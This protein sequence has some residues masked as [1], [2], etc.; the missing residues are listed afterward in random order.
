M[1]SLPAAALHVD[2]VVLSTAFQY[3]C[4]K[5]QSGKGVTTKYLSTFTYNISVSYGFNYGDFE[6]ADYTVFVS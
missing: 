5:F 3:A 6:F 1:L 2:K 4:V